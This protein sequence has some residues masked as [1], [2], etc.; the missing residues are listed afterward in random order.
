MNAPDGQQGP[1]LIYDNISKD[2]LIDKSSYTNTLIGEQSI[3]SDKTLT[4]KITIQNN[5]LQKINSLHSRN[6]GF[7]N[8]SIKQ[9]NPKS[10][11]SDYVALNV[12]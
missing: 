1:K 6:N 10:K 8:E 3:Y 7:E 9:L 2:D 5:K 4:S 11:N 12:K